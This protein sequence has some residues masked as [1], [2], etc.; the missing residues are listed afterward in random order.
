MLNYMSFFVPY[1]W[2][3]SFD[4]KRKIWRDAD[5]F[6]SL[7]FTWPFSGADCEEFSLASMQSWYALEHL[8]QIPRCMSEY[9]YVSIDVILEVHGNH[10]LHQAGFLLKRDVL[11]T[12]L[13]P[14]VCECVT[15]PSGAI[16]DGAVCHYTTPWNHTYNEFLDKIAD[17][18]TRCQIWHPYLIIPRSYQSAI[19]ALKYSRVICMYILT[20]NRIMYVTGYL[21]H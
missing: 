8:W 15:V 19:D 4:N 21:V 6:T 17:R 7:T 11:H 10:Y 14:E 16:V 2:E 12:M 20:G 13:S 9:Q 5:V 3:T 1:L 18:L